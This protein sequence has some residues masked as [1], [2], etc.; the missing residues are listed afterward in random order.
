[1]LKIQQVTNDSRQAQRLLLPDGTLVSIEIYFI[2]MQQGWFITSLSYGTFEVHGIRITN[3]PNILYPFRNK[4]PFG[5]ACFSKSEREPM[6]QEDFSTGNS[7]LYI[8]T[9]T[10]VGQYTD[11]LN[12]QS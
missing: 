12:G 2:P 11:F 4:I 7:T 3:N 10:E 1:M 8:L 9:E 6:F 5:L